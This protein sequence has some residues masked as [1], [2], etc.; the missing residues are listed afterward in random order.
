MEKLAVVNQRRGLAAALN[1]LNK[2]SNLILKKNISR[3][4]TREALKMYGV[5]NT[6]TQK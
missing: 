4:K 3:I 1:R 5:L 6:Q 2:T